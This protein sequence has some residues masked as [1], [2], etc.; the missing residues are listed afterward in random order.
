MRLTVT[1]AQ[2]ISSLCVIEVRP[3]NRPNDCDERGLTLRAPEP[4]ESLSYDA[5]L[6]LAGQQHPRAAR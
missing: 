2:L 4:R 3:T 1:N 5:V 6:S